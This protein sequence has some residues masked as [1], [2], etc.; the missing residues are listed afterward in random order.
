MARYRWERNWRGEERTPDL[1][2]TAAYPG[3]ERD[4][5]SPMHGWLGAEGLR[6]GSERRPGRGYDMG[7]RGSRVRFVPGGRSGGYGREFDR[8]FGGGRGYAR[9]YDR[10]LG[11]RGGRRGMS[12]RY[13]QGW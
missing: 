13:D 9:G 11:P 4:V 10:D 8:Q 12:R 1:N 6:G 2:Y 3:L 5:Q 7:Y